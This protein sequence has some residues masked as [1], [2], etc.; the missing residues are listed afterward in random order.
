M[1]ENEKRCVNMFRMNKETLYSLCGDLEEKYGL[2]E[3]CKMSVL[4]K[5]CICLYILS[6]GAANRQAQERF[7]RSG[8]TVSRVFHEVMD[9]LLRLSIDLIRL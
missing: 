2:V 3:S 5:L 8:E 4:E 9:A 6:L 7:Q 1:E